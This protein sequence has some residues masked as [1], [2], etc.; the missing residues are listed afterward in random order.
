MAVQRRKHK[1]V[2]ILDEF[3]RNK[4]DAA[5]AND[6]LDKNKGEIIVCFLIMAPLID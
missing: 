2:K 6:A 5:A 3:E 1:V 4:K